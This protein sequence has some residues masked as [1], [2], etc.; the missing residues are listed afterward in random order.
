MKLRKFLITV[1]IAIATAANAVTQGN[2][3]ITLKVSKVM[4]PLAEQWIRA[5]KNVNPNINIKMVD[6][7][8]EANLLLGIGNGEGYATNVGR[9]AVLPVTPSDNPLI[10]DIQNKEWSGKDLKRL[11]FQ[12]EEEQYEDKDRLSKRER[13]ASNLTVISG[14]SKTSASTAFAKNFGFSRS[15]I[16]GKRIAGDDIYLLK[17]IEKNKQSVTFNAI[18]NLFDLNS[19][20]L[21]NNITLFPLDVKKEL[22]EALNSGNLDNALNELEKQ[23]PDLVVT[24]RVS[25]SYRSFNTDI[26][27]FLQWVLA[28]GQQINHSAGVLRLDSKDVKSEL[29]ALSEK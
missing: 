23:I 14:N 1:A 10:K 28:D 21:K 20:Q 25:F 18:S 26:E 3:T 5:Y 6:K 27:A 29:L 16:R 2:G 8:E 9:V 11:F 15:D 19:R 12:T 22:T 13:L 24:E 7:D 17:A 4:C